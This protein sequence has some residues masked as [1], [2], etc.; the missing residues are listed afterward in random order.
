MDKKVHKEFK[1]YQSHADFD[2]DLLSYGKVDNSAYENDTESIADDELFLS[3][4]DL[5]PEAFFENINE[6]LAVDHLCVMSPT[7]IRT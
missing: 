5:W 7:A 2:A 6:E 1:A 4:L 3:D